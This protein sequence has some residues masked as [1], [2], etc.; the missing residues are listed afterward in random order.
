MITVSLYLFLSL[1]LL[2]KLFL[3]Q[4]STMP[5]RLL[6]PKDEPGTGEGS[7]TAPESK[8]CKRRAVSSACIPCRKRKSKVSL[9]QLCFTLTMN[10]PNRPTV[11]WSLPSLFDLH[12]SISLGM[13]LRRRK[14][15]SSE[16]SDETRH[17]IATAKDWCFRDA[18]R[19]CWISSNPAETPVPFLV[20]EYTAERFELRGYSCHLAK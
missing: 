11:R 9:S 18:G 1:F 13:P 17:S 16:G 15:S 19:H 3:C 6:R 20:A 5:P 8:M 7:D 2:I 14:R 10:F 12:R 4:A